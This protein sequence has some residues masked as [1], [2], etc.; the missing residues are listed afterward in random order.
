LLREI[1]DVAVPAFVRKT[2]LYNSLVESTLRFMIEQVGQ[3][4]GAYPSETKLAE[5]FLL[6]RTAGNGLELI[7]VLTFRASP[8]W[9]MAALA[10]I[11]GAGR[12]LIREIAAEMK[13]EGLLAPDAEV[14]TVEQMLDGLERTAGRVAE[15]V[16]TPPLDVKALRQEWAEISREISNIPAPNIP[17]AGDVWKSWRELTEE[18]ARQ[19]RSVWELSSLIALGTVTRLPEN[20]LWLGKS[21]ALATR[22]TGEMFAGALLG[23]YRDALIEIHET[24]YFRYLVRE[25]RPYL[26]A[27]AM[28]FS[29]KRVSLTQKLLRRGSTILV[30]MLAA[31]G[32]ASAQQSAKPAAAAAKPNPATG[33]KQRAVVPRISAGALRGHV[34]FLASDAL[35]GRQTP[36]PELDIAAEYIAAQFRRIGLEPPSPDGYFQISTEE[37]PVRTKSKDAAPAPPLPPGQKNVIGVLRGRDP[38]LRDQIVIVSSHYDHVGV[39]PEL[40]G[41]NIFNGANDNASSVAGMI[42]AAAALRVMRPRRTVVFI[43]FF[44]EEKGLVGSGYYARNPVFPIEKTVANLNLEQLGRTDDS[45]APR[46]RAAVLTGFKFSEMSR[47][48][49]PAA[50]RVGVTIQDHVGL[51]DKFF[52]ASD[53]LPLALAGIPAHTMGIAFMFP[54]YHG[55]DDE[56]E[57]LDYDN[58][59]IITRAVVAGAL[60]LA[61]RTEPP[62]WIASPSTERYTQN[63]TPLSK[64][65]EGSAPVSGSLPAS[66]KPPRSKP[67]PQS[68]QH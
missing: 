36:S 45:E 18:S 59:A 38:I 25:Y 3:V 6:R 15:A 42:E 54:D 47:I 27:A 44:G 12:Q 19:K 22:R 46:V 7:G 5:D 39:N 55:T 17:S 50:A 57:K 49:A 2:R 33:L 41:D 43:A 65:R 35:R 29:P 20:L 56:W 64:P 14:S 13:K 53:N 58:M 8:V 66:P 32:L 34:S 40:E 62:H 52:L 61:N 48:I 16:N 26:R 63:A 21:A 37:L 10:D 28:Q 23:H 24:G 9:V 67:S 51:G 4:E 1:G 68:L 11:S 60:A 31:G 30:C